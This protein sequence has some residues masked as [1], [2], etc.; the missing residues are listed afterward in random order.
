MYFLSQ[1]YRQ[2]YPNTHTYQ[3][4]ANG[5]LTYVATGR[6]MKDGHTEDLISER[7]LLW[8]DENR[9]MAISDNGYV[10]TYRYDDTGNRTVKLSGNAVFVCA[11]DSSNGFTQTNRFTAY[12]N[13]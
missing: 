6:K 1:T 8:D 9:L 7:K 10:S 4:D 2:F 3:Y 5:N 11:S 12:H 13:P